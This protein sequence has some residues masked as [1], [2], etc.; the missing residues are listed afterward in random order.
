MDNW[1]DQYRD[2]KYIGMSNAYS[3]DLDAYERRRRTQDQLAL[4]KGWKL[5]DFDI[6]WLAICRI[7]PD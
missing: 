6:G 2:S 3:F 5:T 4:L 1:R 7:K